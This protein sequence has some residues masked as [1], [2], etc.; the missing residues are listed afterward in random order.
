MQYTFFL[1]FDGTISVADTCEMLLERYGNQDSWAVNEL[2]L[3]K[4]ISTAECARLTFRQMNI[5]PADIANLVSEVQ[6][7]PYF[8]EF[9]KYC[10]QRSYPVNIL[11]DGYDEIIR[12]VLKR[13]QLELPL[14]TNALRYDQ[15]YDID[16]PY[17]NN[18]C[19]QCGT[20]KTGLIKQL[21]QPGAKKIYIGDGTSDF[22]PVQFCDIVFAK[23]RLR[24]YCLKKDIKFNSYTTFQ[25]VIQ[26]LAKGGD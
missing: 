23:D 1:D 6:I 13:E 10:K 4:Q 22:C 16:F 24:E 19:G 7:D 3:N 9:L 26:W 17:L 20:C 2:W 18:A 21:E 12:A 15:G 11:S 5:S 8:K 14:Y 25:D